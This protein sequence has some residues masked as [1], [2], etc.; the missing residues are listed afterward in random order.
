MS[1]E[2]KLSEVKIFQLRSLTLMCVKCEKMYR[3]KVC[4]REFYYLVHGLN[5]QPEQ[6][7]NDNPALKKAVADCETFQVLYRLFL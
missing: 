3:S 5:I 1:I 7:E 4:V 2:Q 6:S